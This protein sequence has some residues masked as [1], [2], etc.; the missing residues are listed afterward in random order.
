MQCTRGPPKR[1]YSDSHSLQR[2]FFPNNS[3]LITTPKRSRSAARSPASSAKKSRLEKT[4]ARDYRPAGSFG[5]SDEEV[6]FERFASADLPLSCFQKSDSPHLEMKQPEKKPTP[7]PASLT[8]SVSSSSVPS[9]SSSSSAAQL[10]LSGQVRKRR[11][12]CTKCPA[13]L[14]QDDCGKCAN[15]K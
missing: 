8:S 3:V 14:R 15:C 4:T 10:T 9:S 11:V 12:R 7:D 2:R 6:D 13:C 1:Q 5:S